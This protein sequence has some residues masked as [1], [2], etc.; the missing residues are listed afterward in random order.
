MTGA[1]QYSGHVGVDIG[2]TTISSGLFQ[3]GNSEPVEIETDHRSEFSSPDDWLERG[4]PS[5]W[6]AWNLPWVVG[7]P[8]SV[9]DQTEIGNTP[10]LSGAWEGSSLLNALERKNLSYTLEN[11][12]N[13]AALGESEFGA[14]KNVD[15]L[16]LL[17]LGT[18]IGGGII[19]NGNIHRGAS[20]LAS[21][22]GHIVLEPGGRVCGC[23]DVGCFEQYGSATG[24]RRTYEKL[25]G[26]AKQAHEIVRQNDEDVL[27]REAIR[28]TGWALGKG[29]AKLVNVLE[30]E[31]ILFSG[32]LA[33]SLDILKPA[34]RETL[35]DHLFAD[36]AQR[37]PLRQASSKHSAL[38]G[39]RALL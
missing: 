15:H 10:N 21:E 4:T 39:T 28:Q 2:G 36:E 13:L 16:I 7:V 23:G 9:L 11:D 31:L 35:N 34:I 12:A 19:I 14:G 27:A 29:I 5:R 38:M 22:V 20:G 17:T 33:K 26:E 25:G 24:L 18:G 8:G 30:P 37:I 3:P 32:G 6:D 1:S